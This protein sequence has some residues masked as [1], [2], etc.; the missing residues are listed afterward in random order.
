MDQEILV[1]KEIIKIDITLVVIN[2]NPMVNIILI[3]INQTN[4][5]QI[6]IMDNKMMNKNLN[7]EE[8]NIMIIVMNKEVLVVVVL[9][10][11]KGDQVIINF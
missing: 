10:V 6:N 8:I 4:I 3:N 5:N 9:E 2:T 7:I 1:I 11:V